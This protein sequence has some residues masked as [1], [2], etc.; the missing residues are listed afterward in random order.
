MRRVGA[1]E[2]VVWSPFC[3]RSVLACVRTMRRA[4]VAVARNMLEIVIAS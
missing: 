2:V 1:A 4:A 3:A